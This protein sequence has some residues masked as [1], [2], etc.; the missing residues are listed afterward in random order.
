MD[1]SPEGED[2]DAKIEQI[3]TLRNCLYRRANEAGRFVDFDNRRI[4]TAILP[5]W[6]DY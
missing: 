1:S 3:G 5:I 6:A 2:P 4:K